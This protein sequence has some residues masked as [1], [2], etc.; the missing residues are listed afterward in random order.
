MKLNVFLWTINTMIFYCAYSTAQIPGP[1]TGDTAPVTFTYN[2][3]PVTYM[4]VRAAD[5]HIWLQ[6]SL[7]AGRVATSLTD[8]LAY[9]DLFQWGRWD[10]GHQL[11]N[12]QKALTSTLSGPKDPSSLGTGTPY[13]YYGEPWWWRPGLPTDTWSRKEPSATNGKCPCAA[14]GDG[15]RIPTKEEWE[16]I[17]VRESITDPVSAFNSNLKLTLSASR[18]EGLTPP[19]EIYLEEIVGQY[20]STT[21]NPVNGDVFVLSIVKYDSPYVSDTAE[22][23]EYTRGA[24]ESVRCIKTCSAGVL[25]LTDSVCAGDTY[26]LVSGE[27]V[28]APGVYTDT[29]LLPGHCDSII[30]TTL[31]VKQVNIT[32]IRS[33]DTLIADAENVS[34]LWLD[35]STDQPIPNGNSKAIMPGQTGNYRVVITQNGCSDTS[36]CVAY[37]PLGVQNRTSGEI[38][39]YPNP[40]RSQVYISST[41]KLQVTISGIDGRQL[42]KA[43]APGKIGLGHLAPGIYLLRVQDTQ[44][45]VLKTEKLVIAAD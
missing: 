13:F 7:G 25:Q 14:I 24:G 43:S 10:D 30:V 40:A 23:G 1:N 35:C 42:L 8:T 26:Q 37:S 27:T 44:G 32:V 22:L 41:G 16:D 19:G 38:Q 9:G 17:L 28:T 39:V 11:R 18:N 4:A 31:T 2:H 3:A 21:L 29:L 12:S 34:Y 20:W 5:G 36:D 45:A 15:W 6:Q 33:G